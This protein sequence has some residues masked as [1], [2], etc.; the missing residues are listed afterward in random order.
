MS[1]AV[2]P[3]G[4]ILR[5]R[6]LSGPWRAGEHM[7][8]ERVPRQE[9]RCFG[10]ENPETLEEGQ[11]PCQKEHPPCARGTLGA[12]PPP[13]WPPCM[14]SL[15]LPASQRPSRSGDAGHQIASLG[16]THTGHV[17]R[18]P[19]VQAKSPPSLPSPRQAQGDKPHARH[20]A[21]PRVAPRASGICA[22]EMRQMVKKK[23]D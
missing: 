13:S 5:F 4:C 9:R 3:P 22:R 1:P 19:G 2:G 21:S 8:G 6:W 23:T 7:A 10:R 20:V 11:R 17:P 14:A 12:W 15:R 16:P 18:W